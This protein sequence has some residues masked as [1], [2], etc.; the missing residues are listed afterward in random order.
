MRGGAK[1][2]FWEAL[3]VG[4]A[5]RG[6]M[7]RREAERYLDGFFDERDLDLRDVVLGSSGLALGVVPQEL[8]ALELVGNGRVHIKPVWVQSLMDRVVQG[9]L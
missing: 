9:L 7:C 3:W 2:S 4:Q 6:W 8:E 1:W 5:Q